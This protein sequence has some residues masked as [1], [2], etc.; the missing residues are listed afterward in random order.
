MRS[1]CSDDQQRPCSSPSPAITSISI[2][3]TVLLFQSGQ[4]SD[5]N[6]SVRNFNGIEKSV[7]KN[8]LGCGEIEGCGRIVGISSAIGDRSL[9]A[10]SLDVLR[11]GQGGTPLQRRRRRRNTR[12]SRSRT[13]RR[14]RGR[15]IPRSS[16]AFGRRQNN[17]PSSAAKRSGAVSAVS[18]PDSRPRQRRKWMNVDPPPPLVN[19]EEEDE[20]R[21]NVEYAELFP[22]QF[23]RS[24]SGLI[25]H[26]GEHS[27][28]RRN[29]ATARGDEKNKIEKDQTRT[30]PHEHIDAPRKITFSSMKLQQL[31]SSMQMQQGDEDQQSDSS[32]R[33]GGGGGGGGANDI[34]DLHTSNVRE[35]RIDM[36]DL[37]DKAAIPVHQAHSPTTMQVKDETKNATRPAVDTTVARDEKQKR[38]IQQQQENRN[39]LGEEESSSVYA[40][41]RMEIPKA[42]LTAVKH[43]KRIKDDKWGAEEEDVYDDRNSA[44]FAKYRMQATRNLSTAGEAAIS[45][46]DFRREELSSKEQRKLM[47]LPPGT[48]VMALTLYDQPERNGQ[49]GKIVSYEADI[50]KYEVLMDQDWRLNFTIQ[51]SQDQFAQRVENCT[52]H[53]VP[54]MKSKEVELNL[55]NDRCAVVQWFPDLDKSGRYAV[56]MYD[57]MTEGYIL[58]FHPHQIKLPV[59]TRLLGLLLL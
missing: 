4:R 8:G 32:P 21:Q 7:L 59:G 45:S 27:G 29:G 15:S 12:S 17:Y 30:H 48:R 1:E 38:I 51:M 2:V 52:L 35:Q 9:G 42:Y 22:D 28:E 39:D 33:G 18:R 19:D 58:Y 49:Y 37:I 40:Q 24:N 41:R 57:G 34:G 11:G 55:N 20:A 36:S 47:A 31:S 56:L 6:A 10:S 14:R 44:M 25:S 54:P 16:S 46:A 5:T 3:V 13:R 50:D 23:P 26:P 53:H 43:Q